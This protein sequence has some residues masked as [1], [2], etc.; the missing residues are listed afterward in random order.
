MYLDLM[1]DLLIMTPKAWATEKNLDK[2]D[3]SKTEIFCLSK[4]HYQHSEY[5][6][7]KTGET[8]CKSYIW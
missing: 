8:I 3:L 6:T 4:E 2:L 1:M 5:I 7:L